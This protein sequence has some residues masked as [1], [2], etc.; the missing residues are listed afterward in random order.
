MYIFYVDE[1]GNRNPK[2]SDPVYVVTALGIFEYRWKPFYRSIT[3]RKRNLIERIFKDTGVRLQ[4]ADCEV[5][6]N[7]VRIEIERKKHKFLANLTESELNSLV[8]LYYSQINAHHLKLFVVVIDKAK[9]FAYMD[10]MKLHRKAWELLCEAIENFMRE[11]HDRHNAVIVTD[12]M[13]RQE[14]QSLAMKHAY[15]LETRTSSGLPLKHIVEMPLFVRSEL[16]EGVQLADL[17]AYN[18]YAAYLYRDFS[19]KRFNEL[20]PCVFNSQTTSGNKID[21]LKIFPD[22]SELIDLTE[23]F[24]SKKAPTG[25]VGA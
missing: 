25:K 3:D 15:F 1:S 10:Q 4:L 16:S 17:C 22:S 12:D 7:W 14:N 9:L 18:F 2:S 8:D 13:S 24:C 6:S 21:G 19:G 11:E 20:V 23:Q 5:K